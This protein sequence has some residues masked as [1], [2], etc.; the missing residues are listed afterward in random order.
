MSEQHPP[1]GSQDINMPGIATATTVTPIRTFKYEGLSHFTALV[2]KCLST[3]IQILEFCEV[4]ADDFDI[5]SSDEARPLKS[6]KFSYNFS[7]GILQVRMPHSAHETVTGLFRSLIDKELFSMRVEKEVY[8]QS[9]PLTE[10]GVWAKEPDACWIPDDIDEPSVVL[11]V[12]ASES[13][14]H[15]ATSARGWIEAA[16]S[17]VMACI[18]INISPANDLVIDVWKKGERTYGMTLRNA[19][20]PAIR[21]QHIEIKNDLSDPEVHGWRVNEDSSVVPA[22]EILLEFPLLVGRP[23]HND[24]EHDVLLDR[25]VLI[26]LATRFLR[27]QSRRAEGRRARD[28]PPSVF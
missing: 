8:C 1:S 16:G 22:D 9:S 12:G 10:I 2:R 13:T 20:V 28:E 4:S 14:P 3:D 27:K 25:S 11:E 6:A 15:L 5:L 26:E 7:T 24:W 18:A 23:A 17:S 19:H 21:Q